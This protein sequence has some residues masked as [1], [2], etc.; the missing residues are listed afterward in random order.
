MLK[1]TYTSVSFQC[2]SEVTRFPRKKVIYHVLLKCSVYNFI[3]GVGNG[4]W[5]IFLIG[6]YPVTGFLLLFFDVL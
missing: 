6:S 1:G 5:Y 3:L 4:V 2:L